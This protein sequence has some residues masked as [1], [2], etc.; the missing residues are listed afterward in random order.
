[1]AGEQLLQNQQS[2]YFTVAEQASTPSTPPSGTALI[3]RKTDNLWYTLDDA[4]TETAIGTT[5]DLT[6]HVADTTSAHTAEGIDI[7]DAGGYLTATDVEAAL[8]EAMAEVDANTTAVATIV[9][10]HGALTGLADD[11]HPQYIKDAEFT[12]AD[13]VLLGTGSGTFTELKHNFS[14]S[15]APG[16]TDDSAAGYA[17]GSMWI[18]TTGDKVYINYDATATAALWQE[19]GAGGGGSALDVT[20]GTTTVSATDKITFS[21]ATVT[22]QGSNDALVTITGGS[23]GSTVGMPTDS[24]DYTG[25]AITLNSTTWA[26]V[27]GPADLVVAAEAG[28]VLAV[29]LSA[30]LGAEAVNGCLDMATIVSSSPVNYVSGNDGGASSLGVQAWLGPASASGNAAGTVF[31]TVASGDIDGGNVTLRLRYRT[32]AATN[33]TL[34]A[35]ANQPLQHSVVNLKPSVTGATADLSAMVGGEAVNLYMTA[36]TIVSAAVVNRITDG[37]FGIPS[38]GA[39]T[40]YVPVAGAYQYTV[41]SGDIENGSVTF[42]LQYQTGTAANKTL[43]ANSNTALAW[44][45]TVNAAAGGGN[46]TLGDSAP[47]NPA[48]GDLWYDTDASPSGAGG[49]GTSFPTSPTT[50]DTYRRTDHDNLVFRY[51]GTRWVSDIEYSVNIGSKWDMT[52][53]AIGTH[54]AFDE[55][56]LDVLLT[57]A[58][59]GGT[60]AATHD[61]SNYYDITI[62]SSDNGGSAGAGTVVYFTCSS[63]TFCPGNALYGS[64]EFAPSVAVVDVSVYGGVYSYFTETGSAGAIRGSV[65]MYYR[66]IAV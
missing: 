54:H 45:A 31:Y 52:G 48:D 6:A 32:T 17:V 41:V 23:G 40:T 51:D 10:D 7:V 8:Q 61:G 38:W 25:G 47:D 39:Y 12:G 50:G 35:S 20:D 24:E 58:V 14:A 46:A 16:S 13:T 60:V 1:M 29:S 53:S 55:S 21:G 11:D 5:A 57:R 56:G 34:N 22:D 27:S 18:D 65:I 36:A 33:K 26:D 30:L 42:R 15:A 44:S 49:S 3:Y 59:A 19:V 66:F 28:D 9:T 63:Q 43:Y 2:P 4:G 37:A 64:A 62:S